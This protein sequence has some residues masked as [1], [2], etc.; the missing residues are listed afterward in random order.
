M[1]FIGQMGCVMAGFVLSLE[2]VTE[3]SKT[4]V[5]VIFQIP[6]AVGELI[7]AFIAMA[8]E[9]WRTFHVRFEAFTHKRYQTYPFCLDWRIFIS[10]YDIIE[11]P[12]S[13]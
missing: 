9:D 11:F 10:I 6:F 2:L 13:V 8:C 7:V 3:R 4:F 12:V 1:L 5:G